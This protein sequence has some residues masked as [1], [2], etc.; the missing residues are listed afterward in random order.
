MLTRLFHH[1]QKKLLA[2]LAGNQ[3]LPVLAENRHVPHRIIHLQAHKPTEQQVVVQLLHQLTLRANRVQHHQQLRPQQTLRSDRRTTR[4]RIQLRQFG[5][6]PLQR[7][8]HHRPY[9]PCRM[10]RR[11]P[12]L[13]RYVTE[14][15]ALLLVVST[16]D[17]FLNHLAVEKKCSAGDF[18]SKLS[19]PAV[20]GVSR[21]PLPFLNYRHPIT[22]TAPDDNC[23]EIQQVPPQNL[24][25][26]PERSGV[27]RSA[28]ASALPPVVAH[29]T[30]RP[31]QLPYGFLCLPVGLHAN[32]A[33]QGMSSVAF[34]DYAVTF[35]KPQSV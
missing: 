22:P 35:A 25:S 15:P 14:Y 18:F 11:D 30:P 1:R 5:I 24:S 26:R 10:I 6:H 8:I 31:P 17:L 3:T 9:A 23:L 32:N 34:R 2:R 28:V 29:S 12:L 16:H 33:R 20:V 7:P 19:R 4:A 27:E 13:H 21:P